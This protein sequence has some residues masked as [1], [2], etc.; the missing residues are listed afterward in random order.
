MIKTCNILFRLIDYLMN[1][2]LLYT[3]NITCVVKTC[4]T[5]LMASSSSI[6]TNTN[7]A[8][9]DIF[10][11]VICLEVLREPVQ[12]VRNEHYF[13]NKCITEHLT[14]SKTCPVCRD[15]LTCET[16][17]PISRVVA[18]LLEQFQSQK[19]RYANRGCT[20]E[21]RQDNVS[22]HHEVCGYAPVP[23]SHEG[24]QDTVNRQDLASHQLFC[25]FRSVSCDDCREVMSQKEYRKHP[26]LFRKELDE[27]KCGLAEV[28]SVLREIQDEQRR[29]GEE[30]RQMAREFGQLRAT[31]H[32]RQ[33][34]AL[35]RQAGESEKQNSSQRRPES[36]QPGILK[37]PF[38]K[39]DE[40]EIVKIPF[41]NQVAVH[42]SIVVAGGR[43]RSYEIFDWATQKWTLFEDALFFDHTDGFSFVYDN[44]VLI[45]GGTAT[46]R[47]ECLDITGST[48][49]SFPAQLPSTECGK[50]VLC[51]EHVLT[52]SESISSTSLKPPFKSKLIAY[53]DG[54]KL[55]QY[56]VA[57]V[58]E[59]AVV[60][61]GGYF[62]YPVQPNTAYR[63]AQLR[64]DV[65]LYNPTTKVVKKLAP[66]PYQL[67]DTTVVPIMMATSLFLAGIKTFVVC[68]MMC[69]CTT[70]VISNVRSCRA[71]WRRGKI[72]MYVI[73]NS[74]VS[75]R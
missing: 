55:S 10:T 22:S 13:C 29:Q 17:R 4:C 46:N 25:E 50:G 52:F 47:M 35:E 26:C 1:D 38:I 27:N 41:P 3:C 59:N 39:S 42:G 40:V 34:D 43:N 2:Y 6:Q 70:S 31:V 14:Q 65:L 5:F 12:C 63:A 62:K 72:S 33:G 60:V 73:L 18:N 58:N 56:G 44:K 71:C 66:F 32:E 69:L 48:I 20:S 8:F 53:R 49:N 11:C 61:L 36:P 9:S 19:C 64:Q 16:L 37:S 68:A 51:G 28:W 74:A 67:A 21:L 15:G 7:T 23:C 57:C 54:V 75:S 45:C 24:C 30:I